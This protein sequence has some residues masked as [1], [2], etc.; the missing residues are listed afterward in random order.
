VRAEVLDSKAVV[1]PTAFEVFNGICN[2]D[3]R[4][5]SGLCTERRYP[6]GTTIF[7]EGDPSDEHLAIR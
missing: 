3:A 7:S 1:R 4:R 5:I 2:E 6:Q